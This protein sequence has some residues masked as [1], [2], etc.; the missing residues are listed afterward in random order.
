V[1]IGEG[2]IQ[3]MIHTNPAYTC[4]Q[5]SGIGFIPPDG[6]PLNDH[7]AMRLM[8]Q[9]IKRQASIIRI[10]KSHIN[11]EEQKPSVPD[12]YGNNRYHGD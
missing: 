7:E 12:Y 9:I 11:P 4:D 6:I 1:C 2:L 8:R 5:C 3:P 10:L